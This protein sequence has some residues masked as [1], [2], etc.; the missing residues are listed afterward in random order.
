MRYMTAK[1][2]RRFERRDQGGFPKQPW[3]IPQF[4][5]QVA[6]MNRC[7]VYPLDLNPDVEDPCHFLTKKGYW[8]CS[9]PMGLDY[10]RIAPIIERGTLKQKQALAETAEVAMHYGAM[11]Q[12]IPEPYHY[13][14]SC[15]RPQDCPAYNAMKIFQGLGLSD[16]AEEARAITSKVLTQIHGFSVEVLIDGCSIWDVKST[17]ICRNP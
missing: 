15:L 14:L 10:Q 5:R 4:C 13:M 1:E 11:G 6:W 7:L 9:C 2:N 12:D 17:A 16:K 8:G 3:M